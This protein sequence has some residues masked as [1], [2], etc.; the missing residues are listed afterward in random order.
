MRLPLFRL[1]Q[2]PPTDQPSN[3]TPPPQDR[4]ALRYIRRTDL[5]DTIGGDLTRPVANVTLHMFDLYNA[6]TARRL[7]VC[8]RRRKVCLCVFVCNSHLPPSPSPALRMLW[9]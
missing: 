5:N 6:D 9:W 1:P 2:S 4:L 7:E 8:G 3:R